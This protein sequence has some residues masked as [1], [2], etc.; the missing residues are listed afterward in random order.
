MRKMRADRTETRS[1]CSPPPTTSDRG[2]GGASVAGASRATTLSMPAIPQYLAS[3]QASGHLQGGTY[4][5]EAGCS[6]S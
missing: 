5:D 2:G 1:L 6:A 3:W 4:H